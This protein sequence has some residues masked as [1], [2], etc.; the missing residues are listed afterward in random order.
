MRSLLTV[1]LTMGGLLACSA[2]V[3][4]T[5]TM[6]AAPVLAT[7]APG[8]SMAKSASLLRRLA[9]AADGYRDGRPRWVVIHR[10]GV[11]GHHKVAGVFMSSE[12]ANVQGQRVGH[13]YE[14]FGPFVTLD[15]PPDESTG[16]MDVVE[17]TVR[18]RD[19]KVIRI[20]PYKV[21]ALFWTLAAFDKFVA[22]YLARVDGAEYAARQRELYRVGKSPL[23][24]SKLVVH[25]AGSF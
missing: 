7:E 1:S 8:D 6:P 14:V 20:D 9:E 18:Q 4:R 3:T 2:G 24:G 16:P 17:V 21:D 10:K 22:P 25:K 15:D 12:E 11:Q 19:G 5:G 23:A 13:D